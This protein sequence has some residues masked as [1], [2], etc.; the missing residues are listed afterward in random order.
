LSKHAENAG[1]DGV[2]VTPQSYFTPTDEGILS[3]Y[4]AVTQAIDIPVCAYNN[5][6]TTNVDMGVEL[7][8]AVTSLDGVEYFKS[9]TSDLG[10]FRALV[11]ELGDPASVFAAPPHMFEKLVHG[12]RGWSSPVA[13][14]APEQAS[15][16]YE[17]I[18]RGNT[19]RARERF[20]AWEPLLG[21]FQA[22]PFTATMKAALDL[23]GRPVGE[24]RRPVQPLD[25]HARDE[26]A[27]RLDALGLL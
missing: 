7:I 10:T 18:R 23:Q 26:V 13:T 1:A 5:P 14:L 24:P 12:A 2:L 21:C 9:G 11:R 16:L 6:Q 8:D 17:Q 19:A 15:N 4:E 3:H 27:T 20:A 22:Y 25:D